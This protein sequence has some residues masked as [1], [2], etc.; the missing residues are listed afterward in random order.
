MSRARRDAARGARAL[1]PAVEDA[2]VEAR[3]DARSSDSSEDEARARRRAEHF[4]TQKFV[5]SIA[6]ANSALLAEDVERAYALRDGGTARD[7]RD[8]SDTESDASE[9]ERGKWWPL[10][11]ATTPRSAAEACAAEM[12]RAE[13]EGVV[14]E[15][16]VATS[17]IAIHNRL[18]LSESLTRWRRA[19]TMV[20]APPPD[21]LRCRKCRDFAAGPLVNA[22]GRLFCAPCGRENEG[23]ERA[24][25]FGVD[26]RTQMRLD[27]LP[28][29]CCNVARTAREWGQFSVESRLERLPSGF[30]VGQSARAR[31]NVRVHAH[32]VLVA[33]REHEQGREVPRGGAA[34]HDGFAPSDVRIQ[35]SKVRRL[36]SIGTSA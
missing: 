29:M 3:D 22:Q 8:L 7:G 20:L 26:V 5:E 14:P 24:K 16:T 21:D 15:G 30:H 27:A 25:S 17:E 2:P 32:E 35:D 12:K 19:G 4:T 10:T 33:G 34:T 9:E 36:R 18:H 11:A 23:V 31:G 6:N 28:V 1:A 13:E